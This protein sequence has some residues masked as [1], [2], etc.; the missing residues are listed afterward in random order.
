[1]NALASSFPQI[2]AIIDQCRPVFGELHLGRV[3]DLRSPASS[4]AL[5]GLTG[6]SRLIALPPASTT[7]AAASRAGRFGRVEAGKPHVGFGP[8]DTDGIAVD[9]LNAVWVNRI[10]VGDRTKGEESAERQRHPN[11]QQP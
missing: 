1:L 9:H 8:I 7:I 3:E 2:S 11:Q 10:T 5:R 4:S 6:S